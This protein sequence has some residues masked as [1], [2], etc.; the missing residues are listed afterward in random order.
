M[1]GE[2]NIQLEGYIKVTYIIYF[3][4]IPITDKVIKRNFIFIPVK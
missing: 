3:R 2:K 4:K 1:N